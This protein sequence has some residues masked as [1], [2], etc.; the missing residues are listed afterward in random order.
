MV[1]NSKTC[2]N[3]ES[4]RRFFLGYVLMNMI[5]LTARKNN[6]EVII[7]HMVDD[8]NNRD[9]DSKTIE[10]AIKRNYTALTMIS[11][12]EV[13]KAIED[14]K[15]F[16]E[17]QFVQNSTDQCSVLDSR[18]QS[19]K[20]I[21]FFQNSSDVASHSFAVIVI[22]PDTF[23][24]QQKSMLEILPKTLV[25]Q[26]QSTNINTSKKQ[27]RTQISKVYLHLWI[28]ENW[29]VCVTSPSYAPNGQI[30]FNDINEQ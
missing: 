12:L 16:L 14:Q 3:H 6:I 29:C 4:D 20:F 9:T 26:L 24:H 22:H 23:T 13:M 27:V 17:S 25:N 18:F 15:F 10:E 5:Y 2:F 30:C 11:E 21:D 8:V 1:L 19:R 7:Y 28:D